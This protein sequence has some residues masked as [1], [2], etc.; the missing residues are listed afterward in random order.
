MA[1]AAGVTARDPAESAAPERV[2]FDKW[3]W[4]ARFYRTRS[5]AAQAIDAG[6]A[7][8]R[9]ERVKPAH[10]LRVGDTVTVRRDGLVWRVQ[11]LVAADRRGGAAQ[12]ALL[13]CEDE[14]SRNAR[15]E[16]IAQRRA[17]RATAPRHAGRP[18]KKERRSLEDFLNEP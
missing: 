5:L 7:R 18:T 1:D 14:A 15:D 13:Y 2:R 17:E 10:A 12:A 6:Q 3:L 8:L 11:V 4:A 16:A 9:D